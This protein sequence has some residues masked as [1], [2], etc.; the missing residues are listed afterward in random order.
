MKIAESRAVFKLTFVTIVPWCTIT[1]SN[2][3][4]ANRLFIHH[5]GLSHKG[6]NVITSKLA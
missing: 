3:T 1:P 5:D 4:R 2:A 6:N